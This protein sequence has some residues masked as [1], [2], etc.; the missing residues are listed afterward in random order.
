M[1]DILRRFVILEMVADFA[2]EGCSGNHTAYH[3]HQHRQRRPFRATDRLHRAAI[4]R[5]VRIRRLAALGVERV[6]KRDRLPTPRRAPDLAARSD[7][8][9]HVEIKQRLL[10]GA[11]TAIGLVPNSPSR[12]PQGGIA[13][14]AW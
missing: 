8:R 2:A 14:D 7:R 11:A 1:A 6:T 13:R 5:N 12:P 3:V 9:R 10:A 4:E